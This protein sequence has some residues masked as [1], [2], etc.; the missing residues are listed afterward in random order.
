M[1][2]AQSSLSLN[3]NYLRTLLKKMPLSITPESVEGMKVAELKE[4][5]EELG[6]S[7]EGLKKVVAARL[8]EAITSGAASSSGA[9][10]AAAERQHRKPWRKQH[11]SRLQSPRRNREP[12]DKNR[13]SVE[14]WGRGRGRGAE[15]VAEPPAAAAEEAEPAAAEPAAAEPAA[16]E[17]SGEAPPADAAADAPRPPP[18][19]TRD[20]RSEWRRCAQRWAAC[21][22]STPS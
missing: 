20:V 6:L 18:T 14:E 12:S 2:R 10:A 7:T 21:A 22:S 3:R 16:A 9:A 15:P 5:L 8:L 13:E 4:A 11:R 17:S 1:P 19:M